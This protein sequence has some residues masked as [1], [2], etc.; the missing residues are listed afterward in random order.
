M[1]EYPK[2]IKELIRQYVRVTYEEE[3]RRA[4]E[5]PAGTE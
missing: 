5:P 4:L 3:L 2:R 1:N